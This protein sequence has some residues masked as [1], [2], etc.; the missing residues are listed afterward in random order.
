MIG[1]MGTNKI[2]HPTFRKDDFYFFQ[3]R[4]GLGLNLSH[5]KNVKL[6]VVL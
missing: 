2:I 3:L 1:S 6:N 4:L 5:L